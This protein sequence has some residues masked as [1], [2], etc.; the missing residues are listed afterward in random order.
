MSK[1]NLFDY[2]GDILNH[3]YSINDL[4]HCCALESLIGGNYKTEEQ[5][6]FLMRFSRVWELVEERESK[7]RRKA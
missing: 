7:K 1:F 4:E 6:I 5:M 3:F 2:M